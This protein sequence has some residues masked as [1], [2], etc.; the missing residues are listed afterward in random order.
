M[1]EPFLV[2]SG[3]LARTSRGGSPRPRPGV[4][5]GFPVPVNA[6][7]PGQTPLFEDE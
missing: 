2:R 4:I 7:F 1:A 6:P 3:Y 5:S